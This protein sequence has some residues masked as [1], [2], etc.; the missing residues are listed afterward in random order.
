MSAS[1]FEGIYT[2]FL[3]Y[4]GTTVPS[5]CSFRKRARNIVQ[6]TPTISSDERL[7]ESEE[8]LRDCRT[9]HAECYESLCLRSVYGLGRVGKSRRY[10]NENKDSL[11]RKLRRGKEAVYR[12]HDWSICGRVCLGG[13]RRRE[14]AEIRN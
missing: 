10:P 9:S 4:M 13:V 8:K 14:E 1:C 12:N 2:I 3:V 5:Q 11:A 6:S 7:Y